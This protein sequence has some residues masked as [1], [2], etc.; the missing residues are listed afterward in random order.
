MIEGIFE[1]LANELKVGLDKLSSEMSPEEKVEFN[2]YK[3]RIVNIVNDKD[4]SAD[5]KIEELNKIQ[6]DANKNT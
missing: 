1:H 4:M 3:Q 2:K 5:K 6:A